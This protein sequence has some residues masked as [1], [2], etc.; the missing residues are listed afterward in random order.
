MADGDDVFS[1]VTY[2][3]AGVSADGAVV[4][5]RAQTADQRLIRFGLSIG[6]VHDFVTLLLRLV[7]DRKSETAPRSVFQTI[8]VNAVSVGELEG[9]GDS[10][11]LGVTIGAREL[12]FEIPAS[13]MPEIG[14]ALM[15]ASAPLLRR[16]V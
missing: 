3:E 15:S 9:N 11:C 4:L 13:A 12:M 2:A 1:V 8:P 7:A 6:D 16:L 14:R 10:G 5:C